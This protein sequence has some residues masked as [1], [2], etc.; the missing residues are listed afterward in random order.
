LLNSNLYGKTPIQYSQKNVQWRAANT[1]YGGIM[2]CVGG[3]PL[4]KNFDF[5]Y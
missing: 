3:N 1:F 5:P 4:R 2:N